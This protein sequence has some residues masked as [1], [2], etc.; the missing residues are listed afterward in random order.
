MSIRPTSFTQTFQNIIDYSLPVVM[1]LAVHHILKPEC[2]PLKARKVSF[3]A[4]IITVLRLF[5]DRQRLETSLLI[6]LAYKTTYIM[7]RRLTIPPLERKLENLLFVSQ[8]QDS[9][10][11]DEEIQKCFLSDKIPFDVLENFLRDHQSDVFLQAEQLAQ[12]ELGY[13]IRDGEGNGKRYYFDFCFKTPETSADPK[14][15]PQSAKY[16]ENFNKLTD[17][18]IKL[19]RDFFPM[20]SDGVRRWNPNAADP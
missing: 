4:G 9:R 15:D 10:L 14:F 18:G 12:H 5:R 13:M 17:T 3:I 19:V 8:K 7:F 1:D 16:Q 20:G 2:L 6:Y 11:I